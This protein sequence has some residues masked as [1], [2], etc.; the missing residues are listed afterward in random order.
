MFLLDESNERDKIQSIN[1]KQISFWVLLLMHL[2]IIKYDLYEKIYFIFLSH[3][4]FFINC[5]FC[6]Y[7]VLKSN[8]CLF[9]SSI[10]HTYKL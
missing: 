6:N 5:D 4:L 2:L 9:F 10:L 3:V 7:V 1:I 8:K